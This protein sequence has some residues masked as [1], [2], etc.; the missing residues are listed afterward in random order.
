MSRLSLRSF[1]RKVR[2]KPRENQRIE[3]AKKRDTLEA[4]IVRFTTAGMAFLSPDMLHRLSTNTDSPVSEEEDT[5]SEEEDDE[6]AQDVRPTR[7]RRGMPS[8]FGS[9]PEDTPETYRLPLPS[10]LGLE[11]CRQYGVSILAKKERALREGQANEALAAVR[12]AIGEKSFLFRKTLRNL[13]SKVKKTRAWDII[14]ATSHRMNHHRLIYKQ[15]RNAMMA[16]G[17]DKETMAIYQ[18]LRSDDLKTSTAIQEPNAPGQRKDHL[19]WIWSLPGSQGVE[20]SILGECRAS[21]Y[22]IPPK[23]HHCSLQGQ[24]VA[25]SVPAGP[26]G[27]GVRHHGT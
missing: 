14:L 25:G 11:L 3:L 5:D 2:G 24:L 20:G 27:G 23:A 19:S 26:V 10:V 17:A 1:I 12:L 8:G 13:K 7:L 18:A 21:L 16:L 22:L 6:P 9:A 15:A 4:R